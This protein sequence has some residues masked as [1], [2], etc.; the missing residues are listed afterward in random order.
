V[1]NLAHFLTRIRIVPTE[2]PRITSWRS[3]A[4]IPLLAGC[5]SVS[6]R[7]SSTDTNLRMAT[8]STHYWWGHILWT[9]ETCSTGEYVFSVRDGHLWARDDPHAIRECGYWVHFSISIWAGIVGNIVMKPCLLPGRLPTQ[10]YNVFLETV[11]PGLLE[12][13]PL[14]VRQKL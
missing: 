9:D 4:S 1:E 3:V 12:D 14:A 5:S 6:R 13:V 10:Q 2:D 7:S 8:S 11:L